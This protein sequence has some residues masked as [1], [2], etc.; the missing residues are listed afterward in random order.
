MGHAVLPYAT[1][2][3]SM[4]TI[5]LKEWIIISNKVTNNKYRKDR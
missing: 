2:Y 3:D 5:F 1:Q 4:V